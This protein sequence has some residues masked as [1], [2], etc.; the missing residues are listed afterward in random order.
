LLRSGLFLSYHLP[1]FCCISF[2]S[3]VEI[4]NYMILFSSQ[5]NYLATS[6]QCRLISPA[7]LACSFMLMNL[8][9]PVKRTELEIRVLSP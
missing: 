3:F 4:S 2:V 8:V 9:N 6:S 5:F 7:F 1:F